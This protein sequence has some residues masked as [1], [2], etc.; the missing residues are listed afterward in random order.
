VKLVLKDSTPPEPQLQPHSSTL[1]VYYT[2]SQVSSTSSSSSPLAS[3]IAST[4]Q[5]LFLEEQASLA[6]LLA[7]SAAASTSSSSTSAL[8]QPQSH[9]SSSTRDP[10]RSLSRAVSP[11]LAS[12]LQRRETRSV[13]YA[14]TY[15]ITISLFTPISSPSSWDIEAAIQQY[16]LSLLSS[17]SISNF[18]I[19][20]Q[21]QLYATFAPSMAAP[22]HDNETNTWTLR[23]EDLSGF[24]NAAE[25]PLSPSIGAGPTLNFILY[26]PDAAKTPLVVADSKAVSWLIPQWG[27]VQILNTQ[28]TSDTL[29]VEDIRPALLTFSRQLLSLLGAPDSL[30]SIPLQIASMTRVRAASLLLSAS[31]TLGSLA[32][33]TVAL[34]MIPIPE[35]VALGVDGTLKNLRHA[36]DSLRAGEFKDALRYAREAD[37]EA[38]RGFFEKSMVGQVY[39]PDE[40]K[41]AVYLPLL[42][43]IAVPLVNAGFKTIRSLV[44]LRTGKI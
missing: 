10:N 31:S 7:S 39:F 44:D 30:P 20:T 40:H 14:P 26:V 11:E 22:L 35:N 6:Y 21:V 27:G 3:T 12:K 33:L 19:D 17:F 42:A 37:Q 24:I 25:W 32:R 2:A 41:V 4:L 9:S 8:G 1:H 34:P 43:P 5:A 13:K 29:T 38:E 23:E 16:F 15:H 18:T 36:C 28:S